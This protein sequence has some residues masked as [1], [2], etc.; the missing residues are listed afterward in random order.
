[1]MA[2]NAWEERLLEADAEVLRYRT[3]LSRLRLGRRHVAAL[4]EHVAVALD[5]ELRAMQARAS[6]T[7]ELPTR[8]R[9]S[10]IWS[11][12]SSS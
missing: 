5:A 1:M 3:R 9:S 2:V 12:A 6:R 4:Q 10:P 7:S 8:W 11:A